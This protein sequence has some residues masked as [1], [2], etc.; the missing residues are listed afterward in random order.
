MCGRTPWSHG[1]P[2]VTPSITSRSYK[3]R[4]TEGI[5]VAY[6]GESA[7]RLERTGLVVME[8]VA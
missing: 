5:V 3:S 1:R 6:K 7:E 2:L 4:A 8:E